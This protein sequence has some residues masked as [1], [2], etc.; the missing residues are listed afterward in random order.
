MGSA[1]TT[2]LECCWANRKKI[3][4]TV[5][6]GARFIAAGIGSL[7]VVFAKSYSGSKNKKPN[8]HQNENYKNKDK[9]TYKPNYYSIQP[10][11]VDEQISNNQGVKTYNCNYNPD[12]D[13]LKLKK[14][15]RPHHGGASFGFRGGMNQQ[16]Y[17]QERRRRMMM[18]QQKYYDN[19]ILQVRIIF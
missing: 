19:Q 10:K 4:F 17:Q 7:G 11:A 8:K 16:A 3:F 18:R 12:V 2:C 14:P 9:G 1:I 5:K 13:P 15:Q 6:K